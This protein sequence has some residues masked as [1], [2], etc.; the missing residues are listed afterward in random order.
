MNII[1]IDWWSLQ[2]LGFNLPKPY[3]VVVQYVKYVG[4][5]VASMIEFLVEN[6]LNLD[7]TL[8]VGHS[9]GA[10]IMG[11]AGHKIKNKVSY[12]IGNFQY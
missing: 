12:I 7:K 11:V 2:S 9:L 3:G 5:Y 10:H 8:L 4:D 1:V 6:G